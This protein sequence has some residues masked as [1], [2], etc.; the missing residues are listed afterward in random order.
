MSFF[1]TIALVCFTTH[2][3]NIQ[4]DDYFLDKP[5]TSF[6]EA[7]SLT[8]YHV[9]EFNTAMDSQ[10]YAKLTDWFKKHKIDKGLDIVTDVDITTRE[11]NED[12]IP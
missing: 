6:V 2:S 3:D 10:S 12:E 5:T 1:A 7:Q 8:Q 11:V 9:A 4:C